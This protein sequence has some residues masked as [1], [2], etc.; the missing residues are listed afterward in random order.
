MA[1]LSHRV[2]LAL[3]YRVDGHGPTALVLFN[4]ANLPLTFW[5]P[6][7][8]LLAPD[9]TLIRLDQRNIGE[10][11]FTGRF[12]LA[13]CAADAARLLEHLEVDRVIAVGHAWG[14]RVAQV[15]A[16]DYPH[17]VSGIVVCGTGGQLPP[18]V[19]ADDYKALGALR[20]SGDRPGWAAKLSDIFCGPGFNARD[21]AAFTALTDLVWTAIPHADAIWDQKAVPSPSYWGRADRPTLL[22]YGEDDRFG[23]RENALDLYGRLAQARLITL[24]DTGHFLIRERPAE[25]AGAIREFLGALNPAAGKT[26]S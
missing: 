4:G 6:L 22:V 2:D 1:T 12:T 21:P 10:T 11:R 5:D 18:T 9:Y 7:T 20:A 24:P 25:V 3:H 13:D 17:N 23:T 14:G 19:N 16:R 26:S 8:A 15:F